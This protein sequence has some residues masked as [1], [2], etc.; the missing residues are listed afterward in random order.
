MLGGRHDAVAAL[1]AGDV[2][3]GGDAAINPSLRYGVESRAGMLAA[4]LIGETR[5]RMP[6]ESRS[7]ITTGRTR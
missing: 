2:C 3:A 4:P 7:G 1:R 6:A 5:K